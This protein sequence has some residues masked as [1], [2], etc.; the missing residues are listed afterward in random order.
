MNL[1]LKAVSRSC[2]K[3]PDP[4]VNRLAIPTARGEGM[5]RFIHFS[6][7]RGA[8]SGE[9][10]RAISEKNGIFSPVYGLHWN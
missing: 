1:Y 2:K 4:T 5:T 6:M 9:C 7:H 10:G 3:I 8:T